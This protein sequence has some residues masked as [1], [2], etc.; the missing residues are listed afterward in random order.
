MLIRIGFVSRHDAESL[1]LVESLVDHLKSRAEVLVEPEVAEK[2]GMKG[3]PPEEMD[4]LH[5]DL[6]VSIGGDGTILR[7]IHKMT[8]PVPILG[9]NLGTLGFLV[10]V[11]PAGGL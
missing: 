11:E 10:D 6:I 7:T 2:M 4:A 8:D 3:T 5:V 1:Q 9:I